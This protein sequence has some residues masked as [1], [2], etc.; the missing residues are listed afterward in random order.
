[1]GS[2]FCEKFRR[3]TLNFIH[4]KICILLTFILYV[5]YDI[6]EF[7]R[8][9][10]SEKVQWVFSSL[11]KTLVK[12]H[13]TVMSQ[14]GLWHLISVIHF[15]KLCYKL[16]NAIHMK[17]TRNMKN[18]LIIWYEIYW[19]NIYEKCKLFTVMKLLNLTPDA[20]ID[21][22]FIHVRSVRQFKIWTNTYLK[23]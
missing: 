19:K 14:E 22:W 20:I 18:G 17:R 3:Y 5:I 9:K 15:I 8:H 16:T 11:A 13:T 1:M 21:I 7:W 12:L 4:R 23:T 10:P 6:F 2:K